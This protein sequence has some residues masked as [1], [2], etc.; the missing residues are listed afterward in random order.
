MA[1]IHIDFRKERAIV[2]SLEKQYS[3]IL[4]PLKDT[5]P[6]RL[7]KHVQ[8]LTRRQSSALC[9][10][11]TRLGTFVNTIKRIIDV[12]HQRVED[13]LRQWASCLPVI[14]YK[15]LLFGAQ[16]NVITVLLRTKFRD[17]HASKPRL[18]NLSATRNQTKAQ[19]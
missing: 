4:T 11:P 17:L 6:K 18:I 1:T 10:V 9:S 5:I 3:D 7:N 14:E 2:K 19:G 8:K 16:T 13:I 15:K 12:L